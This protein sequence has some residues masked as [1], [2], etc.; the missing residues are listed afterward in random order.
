MIKIWNPH[1]GELVKTIS[2]HGD[3]VCSAL[4][5]PKSGLIYSGGIDNFVG[6]WN[7]KGESVILYN[8]ISRKGNSTPTA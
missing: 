5:H 2:G 8:L 3:I 6:I 4:F 7:E 1:T